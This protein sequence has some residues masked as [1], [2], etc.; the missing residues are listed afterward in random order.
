MRCEMHGEELAIIFTKDEI[1][2][3]LRG[4]AFLEE[5]MA[6]ALAEYDGDI[7]AYIEANT[8]VSPEAIRQR[9]EERLP[10]AKA[11]AREHLRPIIEAWAMALYEHGEEAAD[12]VMEQWD[13]IR[14]GSVQE[15]ILHAKTRIEAD[16]L[17]G[18]S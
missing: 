17:L 3:A 8:D 9:M 2:F 1:D 12:A 5:S 13:M 11:R 7:D 14:E 10:E 15:L 18:A 4:E 6:G 16:R